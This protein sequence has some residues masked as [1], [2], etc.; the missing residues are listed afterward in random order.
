M[1]E[2]YRMWMFPIRDYPETIKQGMVLAAILAGFSLFVA[3]DA[4]KE[5]LKIRWLNRQT[6]MIFCYANAGAFGIAA[7]WL[8]IAYFAVPDTGDN[9]RLIGFFWFWI[10]YISSSFFL[11]GLLL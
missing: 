1:N 9:L 2:L 6:M 8:G 3:W 11:L 5:N 10:L 4:S 7:A